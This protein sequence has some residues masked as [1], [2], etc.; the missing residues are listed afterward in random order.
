MSKIDKKDLENI[1]LLKKE[2]KLKNITSVKIKKGDYEIEVSSQNQ[3]LSLN[4]ASV[5]IGFSGTYLAFSTSVPRLLYP[6]TK[7]IVDFSS[8]T[9]S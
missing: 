8:S 6:L 4:S 1:A 5:T 7:V 9:M 2:L 3:S